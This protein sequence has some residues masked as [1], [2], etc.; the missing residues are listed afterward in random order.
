MLLTQF[1]LALLTDP[2]VRVSVEGST[3]VLQQQHYQNASDTRTLWA[4]PVVVNE[5]L[6]WL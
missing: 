1:A 6:L 5:Q 4:I 2:L 3:L